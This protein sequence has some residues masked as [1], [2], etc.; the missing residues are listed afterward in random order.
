MIISGER[1]VAIKYSL[2]YETLVATRRLTAAVATAWAIAFASNLIP[3]TTMVLTNDIELAEAIYS[4]LILVGIPLTFAAICYCQVVVFLESR[5]HRQHI[6]AHQ[7]S[8]AAAREI[9]KKDKAARTM[10]TVVGT[11]LLCYAPVVLWHAVMSTVNVPLEAAFGAFYIV[12]V[13]TC[14]NSLV[15]PIIYCMRTQDFKRALRELFGREAPQVNAQAAD[16]PSR[17][18]RRRISEA[19]R[20]SSGGKQ[21]ISPSGRAPARRSRAYSL[22]LSGELIN[23]RRNRR[24]NSV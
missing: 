16:I 5:R 11:L 4:E 22:D 12:D 9:L 19:P 14:A 1:Y 21:Q 2:R 24:T 7:V 10:S 17:A 18:I 6:L 3:L 13:F 20:P 15:N 8:E 23:E